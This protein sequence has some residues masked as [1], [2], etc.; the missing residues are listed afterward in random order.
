M[1]YRIEIRDSVRKEVAAFPRRDQ[2][3][4]MAAIASLA[5][6]PRPLGVRKLSGPFEAYRIRVGDYRVVY[7]IADKVLIVYIVRVA[8]RKDVYRGL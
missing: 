7:Q 5:Q 3:R 4:V 8:H 1:S 6:E 2:H